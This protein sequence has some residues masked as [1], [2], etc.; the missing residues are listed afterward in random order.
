LDDVIKQAKSEGAY[1]IALEQYPNSLSPQECK[2]ILAKNNINSTYL[3]LG[4]EV[5]G[6][7]DSVLK[8]AD[9]ILEIPMLGT[10]ESLNVSVATAIALY[11]LKK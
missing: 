3:I 9:S 1:I 4:N 8:T 5:H 7:N 2:D 6:V 11:E 10:K